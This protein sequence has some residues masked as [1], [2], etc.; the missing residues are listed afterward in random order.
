MASGKAAAPAK[1]PPGNPQVQARVEPAMVARL[2][3]LA[4]AIGAVAPPGARRFER[5]DAMRA[6]MLAGLPI[7][8]AY[9]GIGEPKKSAP[10]AQKGAKR[11]ARKPAR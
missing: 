9:Y 10:P 2:D 8:E 4:E 6:A 11:P 5:S 3:A 7:L 1:R